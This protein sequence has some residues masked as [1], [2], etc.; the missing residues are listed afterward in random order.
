MIQ[1]VALRRGAE[2][3]S[4]AEPARH[5]DLFGL[6]ED[7]PEWEQGFVDDKGTFFTRRAAAV[8][9]L[10]FGQVKWLRHEE[11]FSEDLW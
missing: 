2:I 9:A 8:L 4:M 5:H 6:V 1:G 3:V 7:A 11:L 10:R